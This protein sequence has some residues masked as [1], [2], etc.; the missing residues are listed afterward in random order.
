MTPQAT[1]FEGHIFNIS[2]HMAR[3]GHKVTILDR[4]YT[5]QDPGLERSDNLQIVRLDVKQIHFGRIPRLLSFILN[6]VNQILLSLKVN[7]YLR[8]KR[9]ET[10]I[11]H[12]HLTLMGNILS[13][14][15]R[16][17]RGKMVYT[18]HVNIWGANSSKLRFIARVTL[19]L[20]S[21][22]M[23]RVRKV[24]APSE[25]VKQRFISR[26]KVNPENIAVIHEGVDIDLFDVDINAEDIVREYGLNG[27]VVM[28]FV[29]RLSVIKGIEYL[30]KAANILINDWEYRD[31]VFLLIGPHQ[32]AGGIDEP[33]NL[34]A[35]FQ[36]IS[37]NHL[38]ENVVFAGDLPH[39][40]LRKFYAACDIFVLPSFAELFPL[41]VTE[42]LASG[43]PVIGTRVGA[44]P[45]QIKDGWN[46]FLIE[47]GSEQ[48]LA[49]RIRYLI[50][51]PEERKRMGINSRRYAE[52]K[53][54]WNK[55]SGELLQAYSLIN[56]V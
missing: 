28:L 55:V 50:D 45:T 8:E 51:N 25:E 4:R 10:D 53:F 52:E 17:L 31:S 2:K 44:I 13:F 23:R 16:N 9:D 36:F 29:G 43:K 41:V 22:L 33:V 1:G 15:N 34:E 27:K 12:V 38:S 3:S 20:D 14:M 56:G 40:E 21:F 30:I 42:A 48:E 47:P 26:G 39:E 5:K 11:V 37:S 32:A 19:A 49:E 35:L 6:E 7:K 54:T 24:I 46:G 18:N